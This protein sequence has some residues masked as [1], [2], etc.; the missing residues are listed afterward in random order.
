MY[1]FPW[2]QGNHNPSFLEF[3]SN[4]DSGINQR[5]KQFEELVENRGHSIVEGTF[6]NN[7]S[8]FTVKCLKHD[9]ISEV[10]V[11]RYKKAAFGV[12]CCA[13]AK[14]AETTSQHNKLRGK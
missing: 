6:V 8:M 3:E 12:K 5:A 10:Q 4:L 1:N 13:S 11:Q 7:K 2:R 9:I 14:Q